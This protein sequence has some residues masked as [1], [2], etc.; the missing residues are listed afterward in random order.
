MQ[1]QQDYDEWQ[2][3]IA[4]ENRLEYNQSQLLEHFNKMY[5]Y[6][7]YYC[8]LIGGVSSINCFNQHLTWI[9]VDITFFELG[10]YE[11]VKQGTAMR[12]S[13]DS[14]IDTANRFDF[15]ERWKKEV[16]Q[17]ID[18]INNEQSLVEDIISVNLP[19]F[20]KLT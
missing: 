3:I 18:N 19:T 13:F 12:N 4:E 20:E 16:N 1:A 7:T 15:S 17:T 10:E 5:Q 11:I 6:R 8:G 9:A 14:G 2:K